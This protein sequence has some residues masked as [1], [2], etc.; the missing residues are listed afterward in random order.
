MK[1]IDQIKEVLATMEEEVQKL[2]VKKVK[3]AASRIR[4]GLQQVAKLCKEG[5][6]E[7]MDIKTQI[8]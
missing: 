6:K 4:K 2:E 5:R 8:S 1:S 3:A 7:A